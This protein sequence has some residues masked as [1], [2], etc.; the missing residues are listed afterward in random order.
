M[1]ELYPL[2]IRDL[3]HKD[4]ESHLFD[5]NLDCPLNYG[6]SP[7][8][9]EIFWFLIG[10]KDIELYENAIEETLLSFICTITNILL[11]NCSDISQFCSL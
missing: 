9:D 8:Y 3:R 10:W 2:L 5:E 7:V 6:T 1:S 11:H 4:V